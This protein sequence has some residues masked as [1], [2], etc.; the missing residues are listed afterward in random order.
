[1]VAGLSFMSLEGLYHLGR[2]IHWG[3]KREREREMEKEKER[4]DK[5]DKEEA[6]RIDFLFSFTRVRQ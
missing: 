4:E 5:Q 1:M 3:L 2:H 6:R